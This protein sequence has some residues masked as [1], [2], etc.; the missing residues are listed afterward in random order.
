MELRAMLTLFAS[1]LMGAEADALCGAENGQGG[2]GRTNSRNGY[3]DRAWDTQAGTVDLALP[4]LRAGSYFTELLLDRRSRAQQALVS[5]VATCYLVGVS[6][7]RVEELAQS[8]GVTQL[9]KS[10]V[11][12]MAKTLNFAWRSLTTCRWAAR[13]T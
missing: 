8:L 12:E 11:S 6:T 5:L 7:R 13:R 9:S 1:H 4:K 10:Q 3:W 2:D